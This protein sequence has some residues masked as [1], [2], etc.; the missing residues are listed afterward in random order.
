[1]WPNQGKGNLMKT[2]AQ[3]QPL[4]TAE[5]TTPQ[6]WFSPALVIQSTIL[7]NSLLAVG[8]LAGAIYIYRLER[9]FGLGRPAQYF[10]A[11][12]T[13]L[14][15]L[16][17]VY[18]NLGLWQRLRLDDATLA[19][20]ALRRQGRF[21]LLPTPANGRYLTIGL[22][23]VGAV[24]GGAYLL[25]IWGLYL[26]M[27]SMT[28]AF[29]DNRSW[30]LGLV[31][32]YLIYWLAGRFD[33][34]SR[35]HHW[36]DRLGLGVGMLALV[37]LLWTSG[38][39]QALGDVLSTYNTPRTW[40]VSLLITICAMLVYNLLRLA[41]YFG[42]TPGQRV[43][44]QGW[45]MLSPNIMGFMVFF[46]G[47]LLLSLY[48]SFTESPPGGQ[49][50]FTGL[51]NYSQLLSLEVKELSDPSAPAQSAL[52]RGFTVLEAVD[53]GEARYVIGARDRLFWI[54]L[55]NTLLFSIFL[56]PL[57]VVPALGIAIVLNAKLPGMKFFRGVY[58]LP[59]V[60]AV[61]G[62]G[63]IWREAMYGS[64]VGYL[65][66]AVSQIVQFLNGALGLSIADPRIVWLSEAQLFA[67][68]L[69]AAW[70]IVGFNTVLYLAGLQGIP[71]T[72]YEA[73]Q[74]DGA[75]RWQQFQHVTLPLLGPTTF[76][77]IVTTLINGLQV[78]NEPYVLFGDPP[79][80]GGITSVFYLYR[81][82]FF[83]SNF[84]YASAIAWLLFI[85]IF[86]IT[87]VQFR[88]QR[89]NPYQ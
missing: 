19:D 83:G 3:S 10:I 45:L 61:V 55:R 48:I 42:E 32:A 63:V 23:Y 34:T 7:W 53:V 9:F 21:N 72:L 22:N 12:V 80:E 84:G 17:A 73:A 41:D 68:V 69:M 1:M 71:H 16:L 51:E 75:S 62:V 27:D 47:P 54:S 40:V 24:L 89:S 60:A 18:A 81:R 87:L 39:L 88:I 2:D 29:H 67:I 66:F 65:N 33:D 76:F 82:T 86:A 74:V 14:P 78:F 15:M 43:A 58:F 36:L 37:G 8:S 77:V 50:V 13:F 44:W 31:A 25:H 79:P 70:Q 28:A 38:L 49:S 20:R 26:G 4:V 52:S 56:V 46:A 35:L 6:P 85:V 57:S 30:L 11:F 5:P 59:S 64:V